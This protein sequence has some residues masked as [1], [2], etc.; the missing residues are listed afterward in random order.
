MKKMLQKLFLFALCLTL[1]LSPAVSNVVGGTTITAQAA[2][3][4]GLVKKNGKYYYYKNGKKVTNTWKTV[5]TTSKSGKKTKNKYYFGSNG[6]AV[7]AKS[8]TNATYNIKLK[9]IKGK[10]YGFDTKARLVSGIY[11]NENNL[12][13]Y[14]FNSKGVYN[15][16]KSKTLR[17]AATEGAD[18]AVLE[19]LLESMIGE[20]GSRTESTSCLPVGDSDTMYIFI[21]LEYE[22]FTVCGLREPDS[23]VETVYY[24]YPN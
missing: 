14:Y 23:T 4:S 21:T 22:H 7:M 15:A 3:K 20:R 6:V 9:T 19:S 1:A 12:K 2:T 16:A 5:T 13:F 24:V 8:T 10:K 11:V 17:A 18:L